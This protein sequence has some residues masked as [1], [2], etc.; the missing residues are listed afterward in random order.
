[1]NLFE[2]QGG[3]NWGESPWAINPTPTPTLSTV[4]VPEPQFGV[5]KTFAGYVPD[6]VS[7]FQQQAQGIVKNAGFT[8]STGGIKEQTTPFNWDQAFGVAQQLGASMGGKAGAVL[9]G[10]GGIGA[11]IKAFQAAKAAQKAGTM[12]A[13]AAKTA[14]AGAVGAAVGAASDMIGAFMPEKTEYSGEKG[15]ITKTM[16]S[17]YDG[18]S[19]A[20]MAL[21]PVGMLVGGIM[22]G[23][24]VLGQGVN[25]LGGGTDGMTTTD[26]ILGSSLF[27]LT[28]IGMVNGFGGAKT[29]TIT[30]D[31]DAFA[32]VGSSYSGSNATVNEALTKSGKKYGLLS[33]GAMRK[34][35]AQIQEA[36]RQQALISDIAE[37]S[38]DRNALRASMSSIYGNNYALQLQGGYQQTYTRVGRHG[39]SIHLKDKIDRAK[40]LADGTK[41]DPFK[42]YLDSLPENQRDSANYRVRDY[43]IFNGR[44]GSFDD[45]VKKGMFRLVKEYDKDG[46]VV[47]ESWHANTV[48]ENPETHEIEYMKAESHPTRYMESDWYEKGLKYNDD[49]T[50]TKLEEGT[51]KFD[52]WQDFVSRYELKKTSPYWK[53][54]PRVIPEFQKGGTVTIIEPISFI[55]PISPDEIPE[56]QK[57]GTVNVIPDGALHARKHNIEVD[58]ITKKGIPVVS[59]EEDGEITQHAEVEREELILRLEVTQ[60]LEELEKRFYNKETSQKEKDECSLEAGKLLVEELL[61]NTEDNTNLI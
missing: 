50:V 51:P 36:K 52:E 43:W 47:G 56:F 30:K 31:S 42:I 61:H 16:D 37:E 60:K 9:Q 34:A 57:G 15:D 27:S 8:P 23:N 3:L 41:K 10:A 26:A 25:A 33:S 14:K 38:Q 12:S 39:M 28:P 54:V 24:K 18:V 45:A 35:N 29:D 44:P 7:Q 58:G 13:S 32:Q 20:A 19:D 11:G 2:T 55:E 49:G 46:N 4:T 59:E 40:K 17:V 22:K 53:Y 5:G 1:M 6:F 48:A 21:G